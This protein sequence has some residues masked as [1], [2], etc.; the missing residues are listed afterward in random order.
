MLFFLYLVLGFSFLSLIYAFFIGKK[1]LSYPQGTEKMQQISQAIA[2][3]SDAYLKRQ[4]S[5][6]LIPLILLFILLAV[7]FNI[8]SAAA[9]LFGAILSGLV[10]Y[11][12]MYV[13]VRG[14][15]RTAQAAKTSLSSALTLSFQGGLLNGL[16]LVGFG[17]FGI[18]AIFLSAYFLFQPQNSSDLSKIFINNLILMLT[19]FGLGANLL[20]LFMR[21]GGGIYTKAADVGAD[22]V[23]KIEKNIPE[24]DPR[25]P[26]VIADNVGD[27]VG[28]CAGM[29][30]D[31]FESYT[32]S[33]I[34]AIIL[35]V[36]VAG[37][38]G[39]ILPLVLYMVGI[40][41]SVLGTFFV[42]LKSEQDS[43]SDALFRGFFISVAISIVLSFLVSYYL[44][45][46]EFLKV[47]LPVFIGLVSTAL[48]ALLTDYFTGTKYSPVKEIYK[49][50]STGAGTNIITGL[51]IGLKSSVA[52]ALLISIAIFFGYVIYG[53]Y[54]VSLVGIGILLL[55]GFLMAMDT[56]GPISDNA[57]GISEM[58]NMEK[59]VQKKLAKLDALGNTT[60]ALTKGFAIGSAALAATS[61]F[62]TY[63]SEASLQA[64]NVSNPIVFI[65][66]ILGASIPFLF[67]SLTMLSVGKAAYEIVKEVRDQFKDG[68]ILLGKKSPNYAKCVDISTQ[69]AIKELI[70]PAILAL[71]SPVL[72]G[73]LFGL[74]ALGGFLV[75]AISSG[76]LMAVFMANT[77]AAW[78]NAKKLIEEEGKKGTELHKAAV[79]GDT[80]GD[81]FKDT[82]G[83]AINPLLKVANIVSILVASLLAGKGIGLI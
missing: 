38:I 26:A 79:V 4:F 65:G 28:D 24:D 72:V 25:N 33:V 43:P 29:A 22:L 58:A 70:F 62:S 54:G 81:P 42:K 15:V 57:G 34:A 1:V 82:S 30:A 9:F 50:S 59:E 39:A 49:A 27:N 32:V 41:S 77:G 64:I 83:P 73:F 11:F 47:F 12:G 37:P 40:L 69:A 14:N 44:I 68:L 16:A 13:A 46:Q 75:G 67:S 2:A 51:G 35:G 7:F 53:F 52:M 80:V 76:L 23:G 31:V 61:L 18:S 6:I 74:E 19:S 3:G 66:I 55:S 36:I 48:I 45:G 56:F 10:G 8:Y 20:A 63:I 71:G 5:T 17:L 60:K 21:V 78:D